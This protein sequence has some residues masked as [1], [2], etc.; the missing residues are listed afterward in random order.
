MK[1]EDK[2]LKVGRIIKV[3]WEG[4]DFI[5]YIRIIDLGK[6]I[7]LG[8]IIW[9]SKTSKKDIKE[10]G[11]K[12]GDTYSYW[13]NDVKRNRYSFHTLTEEEKDIIRV[14]LL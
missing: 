7:V 10:A 5:D 13:R 6:D 8:R 9:A 4:K 3:V 12:L 2:D 14:E 11:L 1:L